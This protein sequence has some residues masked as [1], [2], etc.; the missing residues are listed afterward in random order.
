MRK[1]NGILAAAALVLPVVVGALPANA[2]LLLSQ[3][4]FADLGATGFGDAPRLLT[5]QNNV[6]ESGGTVAG[7]GGTTLLTGGAISGADKSLVYNVQ[8]L[9][10]TSGANV[11]IGLDTDEIGATAGLMFNA[12]TMTIY[13]NAGTALGS[14]SGDSP[15]FISAALLALQQ[16]NGN[17]VFNI[18]L[19]AAQQAQFNALI[20]GHVLTD[21]YVGLSASLGCI[22]VAPGCGPSS[23][24]PDSFLAFQQS[25]VVTPL[26]P[27]ALL[28]ASGLGGLMM[29]GGRRRKR[30][31]S[32]KLSA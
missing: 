17:S 27:A 15:V 20:A 9:G 31:L 28:F 13:N 24:G 30:Q 14:F 16:G 23:D 8:V 25:A 6:L 22:V 21:L 2:S 10:W 1:L 12:L 7:V 11:G 32:Q 3:E 18:G 19:D 26:P 5:L 4:V 29:L